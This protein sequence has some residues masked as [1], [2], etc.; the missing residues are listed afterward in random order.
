[1]S[2]MKTGFS[3]LLLLFACLTVRAEPVKG[4]YSVAV[5]VQSQSDSALGQAAQAGL[6]EVLVRITGDEKVMANDAAKTIVRNARRY[7]SQYRYRKVKN[8]KDKDQLQVVLEFAPSQLEA[9]LR[10][11]GIALW[12]ANR[13]S[14]LF[15]LVVDDK[16]GRSIADK[17]NYPEVDIAVNDHSRRRGLAIREPLLDLRDTTLANVKTLWSLDPDVLAPAQKRYRADG[18][19]MGRATVLSNG[20]WLGRWVY[21]YGEQTY[22]FDGDGANADG[23]VAA[24]FDKLANLQASQF[25]IAPQATGDSVLMQIAGLEQYGDYAAAVSYLQGLAA[26]GH[27]NVVEMDG[28]RVVFQL[29]ADGQLS[30]LRQ[31]L[32]LDRR[33]VP[34][35]EPAGSGISLY[36]Q[37]R[38]KK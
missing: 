2:M 20:R 1:M 37:W 14:V 8:D 31:A 33:L 16:T 25:A 23:Y 3:I 19:L 15:W 28:D 26:I 21:R 35:S 7:L 29:I 34:M 5:D 12:P 11:K 13:P 6:G 30:Q 24:V 22:A 17:D 36:Y 38:G 18:V 9:Q 4:L 32:A 27:A 10:E